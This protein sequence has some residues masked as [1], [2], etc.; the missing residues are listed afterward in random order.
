MNALCRPTSS[1]GDGT[2]SCSEATPKH[3]E[4]A[5]CVFGSGRRDVYLD[6]TERIIRTEALPA[7]N[8]QGQRANVLTL[9]Y[10]STGAKVLAQTSEALTIAVQ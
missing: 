7:Q 3:N 10:V 9:Q 4:P 2:S 5:E 6:R 8:A 1:F